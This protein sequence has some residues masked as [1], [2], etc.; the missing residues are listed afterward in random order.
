MKAC[1]IIEK[2]NAEIVDV[3]VP[4]LE[5]KQVLIRVKA[6]GLCG[7]DVHIFRGDYFSSYPII[8]GHEFSGIVQEVGRGV[9]EFKPGEN[10][11]ADP[12]NFCENCFFCKQNLQNH[13]ENFEATGVTY[14]GAFAEFVAVPENSVFKIGDTPFEK[15]AFTE[16]LACVVYGQN[17]IS[18]EIGA[19]LLIFGAG[20]IGLLH[21]QLARHNGASR[22]TVVDLNDERLKLAKKLG[23]D[24]IV[25]ADKNMDKNLTLINKRGFQTVIDA[26]GAKEVIENSIKYIRCDGQLLLFGVCGME[27]KIEIKPYEIFKR[28]IKIVGSFA[29]RKT[30]QSSINLIKNNVIDVSSLIGEKIS[31][32]EVP[33]ALRRMSVGKTNMKVLAIF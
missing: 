5:D 1:R 9:T 14:D 21:L 33:D 2:E 6:S 32:D 27:E 17:R 16:P 10:V 15:A 26:T 4:Q 23:A 18:I 31:L 3:K 25:L 29:L 13:C 11:T 19:D 12:N 30:F 24:N 8:P 28:D 7:T 20:P 22:V